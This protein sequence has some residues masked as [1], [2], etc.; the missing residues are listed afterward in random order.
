MGMKIIHFLYVY[1]T[2]KK[3]V[4]PLIQMRF[5]LYVFFLS[6]LAHIFFYFY[7]VHYIIFF[8]S[9]SLSLIFFSLSSWETM[10]KHFF[11]FC[12]LTSCFFFLYL[13]FYHSSSSLFLNI[14][15]LFHFLPNEN[16]ETFSWFHIS[17][18]VSLYRSRLID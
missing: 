3:N 7:L 11:S 13:F 1:A 4:H 14:S 10:M 17:L 5:Y 6:L 15:F 16:K 2:G 12:F 8:S 9:F 18:R